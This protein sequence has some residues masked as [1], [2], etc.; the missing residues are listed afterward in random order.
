MGLKAVKIGLELQERTVS[1]HLLEIVSDVTW[2][3]GWREDN[4]FVDRME[5]NIGQFKG[6]KKFKT[7]EW[8]DSF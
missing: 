6:Y 7:M 5:T 8:A 1:K 2:K 4:S 3:D